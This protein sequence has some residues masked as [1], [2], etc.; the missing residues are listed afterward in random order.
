M[1]V[2]ANFVELHGYRLPTEWEW[3]YAGRAETTTSRYYGQMEALLP[4]YAWYAPNLQDQWLVG[5]LKPNDFGLF[6][7]LGNA[8]EWCN[9]RSVRSDPIA[10]LSPKHL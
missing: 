7:M 1:K 5:R 2:K 3:E 6:D 8:W 10:T 4:Q 9:D